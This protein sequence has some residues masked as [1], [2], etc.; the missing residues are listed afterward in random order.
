MDSNL[1]R[2][3]KIEN[4]RTKSSNEKRREKPK[5]ERTT[6]WNNRSL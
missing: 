5:H 2:K 4:H 6:L 3:S 1:Q